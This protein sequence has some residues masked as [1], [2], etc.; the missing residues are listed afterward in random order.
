MQAPALAAA[1]KLTGDERY[2]KQ[3]GRHLRA[4]FTEEATRMNPSLT[5]AQAIHGRVTGRGV[6]II[7]TIHLEVARAIEGSPALSRADREGV[8]GWFAEYLR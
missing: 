8:R 5:Y 4:W 2:A 7:D 6:G 1:F 3:A